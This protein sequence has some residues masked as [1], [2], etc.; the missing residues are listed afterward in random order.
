M[1]TPNS[2][3]VQNCID[4]PCLFEVINSADLI[5][6]DG[7]GV[8]YASKILGTPLKERVAGYDLVRNLFEEGKDFDKD[9]AYLD[10]DYFYLYRGEKHEYGR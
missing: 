1:V 3:I 2:E 8:I 7:I 4:L 5:I 10:G 6:P 9:H